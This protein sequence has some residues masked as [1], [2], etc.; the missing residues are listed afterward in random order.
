ML[1]ETQFG[2]SSTIPSSLKPQVCQH[3][4]GY[5]AM[6]AL[7][8]ALLQELYW[9]TLPTPSA[10]DPPWPNALSGNTPSCSALDHDQVKDTYSWVRQ[11]VS[12]SPSYTRNNV[13][14]PFRNLLKKLTRRTLSSVCSPAC[15]HLPCSEA[16]SPGQAMHVMYGP[17]TAAAQEQVCRSRHS[18]NAACVNCKQ[19]LSPDQEQQSREGLVLQLICCHR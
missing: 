12:A 17:L 1:H 10:A 19:L 8:V 13:K 18:G 11:Q 15:P 16:A 5:H 2:H 7:N 9:G 14:Q 3:N 4:A 6:N